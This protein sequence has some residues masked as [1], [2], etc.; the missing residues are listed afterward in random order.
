MLEVGRRFTAVL[1]DAKPFRTFLTNEPDAA[2]RVLLTATGGVHHRAVQAQ[3]EILTEAT[4]LVEA[5][6]LSPRLD[7]RRFTLES[8]LDAHRAL[9]ERTAQGKLVVDL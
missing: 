2:A 1:S 6:Q 9:T 8:V 5:G 7:P 3:R 4:R